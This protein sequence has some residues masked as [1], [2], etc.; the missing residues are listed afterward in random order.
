LD[1]AANEIS[2]GCRALTY[3]SRRVQLNGVSVALAACGMPGVI[4]SLVLGSPWG[5]ATAVAATVAAVWSTRR[6][7]RIR[8][9]VTEEGVRVVN[10]LRSHG[11]KWSDIQGVGIALKSF[12]PRPA[13]AFKLREGG[14]VF[15][16]AT[17]GR[18]GERQAFQDAVLRL[19]P[20]SVE[21]LPDRAGIIGTD[22]ALSNRLLLWWLRNQAPSSRIEERDGECVW[23]EQPF[24][25]TLFFVTSGVVVSGLVAV[26]GVWVLISAPIDNASAAQY[27]VG[28]VFLVVGA[29]AGVALTRI[30]K[31][32]ARA[33]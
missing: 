1:R 20:Q 4:G 29:A 3:R 26:L 24:P 22:R 31:R 19:A 12:F 16:Q 13:L 30:L 14:A 15:A 32:G 33:A 11:L 25:Y 21:A 10:H 27:L 17:P 8:L 23:R 5:Y 7:F 28:A 2:C 18:R 6:A 9:T